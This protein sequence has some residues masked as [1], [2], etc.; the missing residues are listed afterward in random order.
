[1]ATELCAP[2]TA[3]ERRGRT[4]EFDHMPSSTVHVRYAVPQQM[5]V[6]RDR[7][8]V[9]KSHVLV[10]HTPLQFA[11]TT[12]S[13]DAPASWGDTGCVTVCTGTEDLACESTGQPPVGRLCKIASSDA[14][15]KLPQPQPSFATV[16]QSSVEYIHAARR[17]ASCAVCA[18]SAR[19]TMP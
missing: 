17:L 10:G 16:Q 14:G 1:M 8:R 11:A 4:A 18:Q 12:V 19:Y 7:Q 6:E 2:R 13:K 9:R 5:T 3:R 15:R